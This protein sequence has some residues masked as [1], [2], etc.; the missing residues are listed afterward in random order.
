VFNPQSYTKRK[1]WD[2][3]TNSWRSKDDADNLVPKSE[4][5]AP[6]LASFSGPGSA[7]STSSSASLSSSSPERDDAETA[8]SSVPE[9]SIAIME[10]FAWCQAAEVMRVELEQQRNANFARQ[11]IDA[12]QNDTLL[13]VSFASTETEVFQVCFLF[14]FFVFGKAQERCAFDP[15]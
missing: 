5:S 11:C 9:T 14:L 8:P 10:R 1:V 15:E 7:F 12:F 13:S 4:T 3:K 2:E 6:G